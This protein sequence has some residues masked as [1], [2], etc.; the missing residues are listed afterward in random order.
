MNQSLP[1]A[2]P[3]RAAQGW[4]RDRDR[5]TL[6]SSSGITH[7]KALDSSPS[8][9]VSMCMRLGG[10]VP[11]VYPDVY[12]CIPCRIYAG[13]CVPVC[14]P[15]CVRMRMCWLPGSDPK[16][17]DRTLAW[18]DWRTSHSEPKTTGLLKA[19]GGEWRGRDTAHTASACQD[20]HGYF[21]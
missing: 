20:T 3:F 17:S 15:V 12:Q 21:A 18:M 2:A 8:V 1:R 16:L 10:Y 9:H 7:T 4:D 14:V 11:D 5:D 6:K 13:V 19:Q